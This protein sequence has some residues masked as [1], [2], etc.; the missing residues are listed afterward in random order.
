MG[1]VVKANE[2]MRKRRSPKKN[3]RSSE[4]TRKNN[5]TRRRTRRKTGL[6]GSAKYRQPRAIRRASRLAPTLQGTAS[7]VANNPI[8]RGIDII[9]EN[10]QEEAA[11]VAL[12]SSSGSCGSSSSRGSRF[13]PTD[14]FSSSSEDD[15]STSPSSKWKQT[16]YFNPKRPNETVATAEQLQGIRH[17]TL[18]PPP[19]YTSER[20]GNM[21]YKAP[22]QILSELMQ[23]EPELMQVQPEPVLGSP[24]VLSSSGWQDENPGRSWMRESLERNAKTP[25]EEI[26]RAREALDRHPMST[27]FPDKK[28]LMQGFESYPNDDLSRSGYFVD[29]TFLQGKNNGGEYERRMGDPGRGYRQSMNAAASI[30]RDLLEAEAAATAAMNRTAEDLGYSRP[31][32]SPP[33]APRCAAAPEPETGFMDEADFLEGEFY[34]KEVAP[35][36]A[37]EY[38]EVEDFPIALTQAEMA[39]DR[40]ADD[41]FKR[42]FGE[43]RDSVFQYLG[44]QMNT[45]GPGVR[46]AAYSVGEGLLGVGA[47]GWGA[48]ESAFN[49]FSNA[50]GWRRSPKQPAPA[51]AQNLVMPV[52]GYRGYGTSGVS[53]PEPGSRQDPGGGS[54]RRRRRK[55]RKAKANKVPRTKRR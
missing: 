22:E 35:V 53:R 5:R 8:R 21:L 11:A 2:R 29:N 4:R 44:N 30:K 20:M 23:V 50:L 3:V 33:M 18:L 31:S 28:N 6:K 9:D 7:A 52:A 16:M 51:P 48:G 34:P 46:D 32:V 41:M 17:G 36:G 19:S 15:L 13:F 25:K 37:K 24:D 27:K 49:T 54:R 45:Q 55:T 39:A 40:A 12:N 1:Y 42:P 38:E 26:L 47:A 10:P 43:R 14:R